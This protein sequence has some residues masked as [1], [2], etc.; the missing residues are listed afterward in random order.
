MGK[1]LDGEWITEEDWTTDDEGRF[2]RSETTFRDRVRADGSTEFEPEAGRYHLYVSYACP[3]AHRTLIT[4]QLKGLQEAVSVSV[5]DPLMGEDGWEFSEA[6]GAIP[7][8][9]NGADYL[10]EVYARADAGYTGRVTVPVLWDR[11]RETIVNNESKEIMRMFDLEF[12]EIAEHPEVDLYPEDRRD[13]IDETIEAIYQPINNGVYR[14]GFAASQEAYETAVDELF[15]ALDHWDE[16]LANRR[17][18][19][20]DRVTEADICMF[21][22]LYRFDAVY[23]IHFKCSTRR[24][25]DYPNLWPYARDLYQ[26]EDF[27]T[28]CNMHHIREHY[29]RSHETVNP[30]RIVAREPEMD[31]EAP[32]HREAL[33]S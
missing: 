33:E 17:Y 29:Y 1:M 5:V 12:D 24:L 19:C 32:H 18:L 30:R 16:R 6:P 27:R 22:T 14:A 26:T 23:H 11:Q 15:E 21:T 31:W 28:T 4:R 8:T 9:V 7:D 2:Q 20:G 10:R 25:V 3:W 13:E